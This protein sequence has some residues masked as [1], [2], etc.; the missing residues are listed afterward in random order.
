MTNILLAPLKFVYKGFRGPVR[1][2]GVLHLLMLACIQSVLALHDSLFPFAVHHEQ[3]QLSIAFVHSITDLAKFSKLTSVCEHAYTVCS[4]E[5]R[6][7]Y[8][9]LDA[10]ET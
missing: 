5:S 10:I 8:Q 3:I 1:V 7:T 4:H 9:L 2:E 6:E